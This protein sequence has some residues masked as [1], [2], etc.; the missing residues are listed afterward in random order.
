MPGIDADFASFADRFLEPGKTGEFQ[1]DP[2]YGG[3]T[4]EGANSRGEKFTN[5]YVFTPC[6]GRL[7]LTT[8]YENAQ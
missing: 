1:S 3:I 6:Q 8:I 2:G 7:V 5:F 4:A